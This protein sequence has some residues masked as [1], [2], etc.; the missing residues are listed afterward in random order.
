MDGPIVFWRGRKI[1]EDKHFVCVVVYVKYFLLLHLSV[2][3][4]SLYANNLFGLFHF[5][6]QFFSF[7]TFY[8]PPK[9]IVPFLMYL[10]QRNFRGKVT[11]P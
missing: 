9:N 4:R 7:G 8:P 1:F 3:N 6:K 10:F 11:V 2:N 5:W